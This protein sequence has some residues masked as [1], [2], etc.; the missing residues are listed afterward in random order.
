M[1]RYTA[2]ITKKLSAMGRTLEIIEGKEYNESAFTQAFPAYF[3]SIG[4]LTAPAA[5]T[6][7][8]LIKEEVPEE[9]KEVKLEL[10]I[11]DS[12]DVQIVIN[13]EPVDIEEEVP[14]ETKEVKP[15]RKTTKK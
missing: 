14:T 4:K 1:E 11:D 15:T 2:K 5:L 7:P 6:V 9:P 10:L 12:S 3:K 8:T 13:E